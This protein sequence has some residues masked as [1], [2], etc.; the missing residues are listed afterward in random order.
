MAASRRSV[1]RTEQVFQGAHSRSGAG[2][3]ADE[4]A[5][6]WLGGGRAVW[7]ENLHR[8]NP[9]AKQ[10]GHDK[11]CGGARELVQIGRGPIG[12]QGRDNRKRV[13]V[14]VGKAEMFEKGFVTFPQVSLAPKVLNHYNYFG[15]SALLQLSITI[16]LQPQIHILE[17]RVVLCSLIVTEANFLDLCS[18]LFSCDLAISLQFASCSC[19]C[20]EIDV[21][22]HR[23]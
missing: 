1:H 6:R 15:L 12:G 19:R 2:S 4:D 10:P 21:S 23:P 20:S 16:S 5:Y 18:L 11:L 22:A 13:R 3:N 9:P 17:L 8:R 14:G 7:K